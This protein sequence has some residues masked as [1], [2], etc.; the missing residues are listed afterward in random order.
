MIKPDIRLLLLDDHAL[1]REG[2]LRLL[3]S[4]SGLTV[5]GS[6]ATIDHALSVITSTKVDIVLLD[7]DLGSEAGTAFLASVSVLSNPPR[8]LM[9]TAGMTDREARDAVARGALGIVLKHSGPQNLIAAIRRT[10]TEGALRPTGNVARTLPMRTARPDMVSL[11]DLPLTKRQASALHGILDGLSNKE[12]AE[13]MM[14][15][16]SSV[17]AILQELFR[18]AGVRTR[19]QLVRIAIEKHSADWIR[20]RQ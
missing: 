4:E 19:S 13:S 1:F 3:D 17:K 9:V 10:M 14:V 6:C 5:V 16:E 12:I 20:G 8:V 7:Y 2:L 18:K 15:S 11:G